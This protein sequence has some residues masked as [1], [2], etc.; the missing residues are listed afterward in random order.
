MS[1]P[2][3]S[4]TIQRIHSSAKQ[5]SKSSTKISHH[6]AFPCMGITTKSIQS[7]NTQ[8]HIQF[9]DLKTESNGQLLYHTSDL[10]TTPLY[11]FMRKHH[12]PVDPSA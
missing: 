11:M 2:I 1:Q 6:G 9:T 8:A 4:S 12:Q 10:K 5:F 3:H 7:A